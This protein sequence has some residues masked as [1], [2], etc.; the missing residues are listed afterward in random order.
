MNIKLDQEALEKSAQE[1]VAQAITSGIAGYEV[2]SLLKQAVIS[3]VGDEWQEAAK[4]AIQDV[5]MDAVVSAMT[6]DVEV[7]MRSAMME[8][9]TTGV[10]EMLG[11]ISAPEYES[12][13]DRRKRMAAISARLCKLS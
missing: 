1:A 12:S 4:K 2:S 5:D 3:A 11:K 13:D 8:L 10:A 7:V 9:L 6:S